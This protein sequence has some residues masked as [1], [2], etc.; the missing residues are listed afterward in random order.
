M[1]DTSP[2]LDVERV[3]ELFDLRANYNALFGGTYEE[4][5]YPTWSAL[6]QAS[7][8]HP[9]IVHEL[10]GF[11]GPA[12]FHGLP[13]PDR[14]HFSAFSY[15]A[16]DSIYRDDKIFSSS[17]EA[18]EL[19]TD[20]VGPLNSILSM[21]GNQHRRYRALVQPSFVPARAQWWIK[22][23][24]ETTVALLVDSFQDRGRAELNVDFCA[25]IPVL[26]I[27]GSFG[28]PVERALD[29][30]EALREPQKMVEIIEPIV[31]ARRASPQ[32]DLISILVEAEVKDDEGVTHRLTDAEIYSFSI[33]LLTAGSGTTWKQMGIT[34][35]ALLQRPEMLQAV[36]QDRTL[37]RSAIEEAL[38]W[39]PTDPMFSRWVTEDI[40]FHGHHVPEGSVMHICLGAANRDPARW[41][42][43]NE[44]EITRSPK[45][46]LAFGNGAHICLGMHVARAEMTVGINALLDRLPDLRLD[47]EAEPPRYIGFYER[48]ATAIPVLFG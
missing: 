34:L 25:A 18:I 43:P 33:L 30:R 27:T 21:G 2:V 1:T 19:S 39:M 40:D 48:G 3:R 24:I 9:G 38:R 41:D 6:R 26:T 46:S 35:A 28:V 47:P 42:R 10:T 5:P 22:N 13:F 29:I 36:R 8:V 31:A 20:E 37:I 16:C 11:E 45:P 15:A 4:D 44:F 23:W 12:F 14:P 7:A 17:P 32:D